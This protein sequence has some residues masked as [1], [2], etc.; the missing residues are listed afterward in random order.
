MKTL[1]KQHKQKQK[2]IYLLLL[3]VELFYELKKKYITLS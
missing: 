2:S 3:D 1:Y